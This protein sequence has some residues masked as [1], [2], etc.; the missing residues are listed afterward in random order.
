MKNR[1]KISFLFLVV[2][3][4]GIIATVAYSFNIDKSVNVNINNIYV[5]DEY[6]NT[7]YIDYSTNGK[8]VVSLDIN[9]KNNSFYKI[10]YSDLISDDFNSLTTSSQIEDEK[11]INL[12]IFD[13]KTIHC[14][15]LVDENITTD[16]LRSSISSAKVEIERY[17]VGDGSYYDLNVD[18]VDVDNKNN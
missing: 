12:S 9:I 6:L 14:H 3:T 10:A 13:E 16:D 15:I 5:D 7:A 8:K 4:A 18:S 11:M 17:I 2:I 1:T